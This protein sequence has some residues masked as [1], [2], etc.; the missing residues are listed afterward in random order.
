MF[1]TIIFLQS[2]PRLA[3]LIAVLIFFITIFLVIKKWIGFSVA[4]LLLIFSLAAGLVIKNQQFFETYAS[5]YHHQFHNQENEAF[6]KQILQALEDIKK[7]V[8]I[9]RENFHQVMNQVQAIFEQMD[10]EKQ[11]LQLFIEETREK[12]KKETAQ[13]TV[14]EELHIPQDI[15]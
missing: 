6:K 9:E 3:L 10:A 15:H 4:L 2:E 1:L 13:Q 11:K 8:N 5:E 7:E 12:F 14:N